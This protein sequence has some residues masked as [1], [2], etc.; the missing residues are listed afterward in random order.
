MEK[1]PEGTTNY[2][3][4]ETL[5][6]LLSE[7][8]NKVE[9]LVTHFQ[10]SYDLLAQPTKEEAEQI[11]DGLV[12][13]VELTNSEIKKTLSE[14]LSE[15]KA[16]A[17]FSVKEKVNRMRISIKNTFN[18]PILQLNAKIRKFID[19]L[20]RKFALEEKEV[21]TVLTENE[22]HKEI[23][24][25]KPQ[26]LVATVQKYIQ[27]SDK[28]E[29]IQKEI[30]KEIQKNPLAPIDDLQKELEDI[31]YQLTQTEQRIDELTPSRPVENLDELTSLVKARDRLQEE[32]KQLVNH[33]DFL[34][35]KEII[36]GQLSP[37]EA[38]RKVDQQIIEL[39]KEITRIKNGLP[40]KETV[41]K[42]T[43]H[44]VANEASPP[45][46]PFSLATATVVKEV[47][48][49]VDEKNKAFKSAI[50]SKNSQEVTKHLKENMK[51]YFSSTNIK[52]YLDSANKFHQY[53][54]KNIQLI[55]EQAPN[56]TQVANK[57]KWEQM[58]YT[59]KSDP[60]PIQIYQPVFTDKLDAEGNI[61]LDANNQPIKEVDFHLT[62]VY[63][64]SQTTDE[65]L[66]H[67]F[68]YNVS[69][70][71]SFLSVYKSME[72]LTNITIDFQSLESMNSHYDVSSNTLT[73]N[74]GLGKEETI[75]TILKE[76][77]PHYMTNQSSRNDKLNPFELEAVSYMIA[78]HVGLDTTQFTFDSLEQ[79]KANGYSIENFTQSLNKCS[80]HATT[81]ISNIDKKYEQM[82]TVDNK[83]NKFEE[84]L[85]HAKIHNTEVTDQLKSKDETLAQKTTVRL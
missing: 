14:N 63:D 10:S 79:L 82:L 28:K 55:M 78:S 19:K 60:Q 6:Q 4:E 16:I 39:E 51:Q 68:T 76:T 41:K 11:K 29:S 61:L 83:K 31:F 59:L 9:Q 24:E 5:R 23:I 81:F 7:H 67:T 70:K 43:E 56:A 8:L 27:M 44:T 75:Q 64:V 77:I 50:K 21:N 85:S 26:D 1:Q 71:N 53:S 58:G 38:F 12:Q 36:A 74:T 2:L 72:E 22:T 30:Q 62:D 42:E 25:E 52:N 20:D 45:I 18:Q 65:T 3:T 84:R 15:T 49:T 66:K 40:E 32:R 13:T 17:L 69:E 80:K 73:I 34:R 47:V 46:D 48:K 57:N 37:L 33:P 54:S 35:S